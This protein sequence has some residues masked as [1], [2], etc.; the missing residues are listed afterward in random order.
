MLAERRIDVAPLITHRFPIDEAGKAYELLGGTT[1][2]L[3]ILLKYQKPET[4]PDHALLNTSVSFTPRAPQRAGEVTVSFIGSGNY[5]GRTLVPAFESARARLQSVASNGGLSSVRLAR[6]HGFAQATTDIRQVLDDPD[7]DAIVI[8]TRHDSHADLVIKAL[9][10][11][12]HVFVEKPLC[13]TEEE[14]DAIDATYRS[15]AEPCL[16]MVGFN[17]RFSPHVL[18][19]KSL[20]AKVAEPKSF[21]MTVNA[22]AIPAGHWAQDQQIGGGR[23]IGEACH[24]IDL[25]RHL[26]GAPITRFSRVTLASSAHDTASLQL[27]FADGSIGTVHYFAN[28]SRRFPKERLEV[29]CGGRILQLDNFCK[30]RSFDWQGFSPQNL[31]RQ[32]KGQSACAAAFVDAIAKGRASP[33]P[34]DEIHEVARVGIEL[35]RAP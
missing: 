10:A 25:L 2:S 24:F 34:Y 22:G 3:G 14:L 35:A 30:A 20:L 33:I 11:G 26:A 16:L 21:I 5:A 9:S 23:I 1:P 13:L 8:A 19:I 27:A 29:F 15:Q 7:A 6:K 31:W 32:D 17:R 12:K 4:K 18:K 28:G